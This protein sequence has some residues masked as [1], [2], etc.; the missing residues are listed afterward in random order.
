MKDAKKSY[1]FDSVLHLDTGI[2]IT[3]I[4]NPNS[5]ALM[6]SPMT[7]SC[8]LSDSEKQIVF[9]ARH[10]IPVRRVRCLLNVLSPVS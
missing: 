4:T 5:Y 6:K 2:F 9:P 8:I 7:I 10:L 3:Y 1:C